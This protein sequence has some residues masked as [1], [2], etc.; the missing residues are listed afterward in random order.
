MNSTRPFWD[1]IDHESSFEELLNNSQPISQACLSTPICNSSM[2]ISTGSM[3]S[4]PLANVSSMPISNIINNSIDNN[5]INNNNNMFILQPHPQDENDQYHQQLS[6]AISQQQQTLNVFETM[7]VKFNDPSEIYYYACTPLGSNYISTKIR[8]PVYFSMFFEKLKHYFPLLMV[9]SMGHTVC[10]A[11]YSQTHCTLSDKVVLLNSLIQNFSK[12]ASNRQ[13]SFALICI[14][15]LVKT[16]T[17]I[18]VISKGFT[19]VIN[20]NNDQN[21]NDNDNNNDDEEENNNSNQSKNNNNNN[22]EFNN[23]ILS[24]SGYHVIKKFISFG[25]P[26]FDC[27]LDGISLNFTKYATHHYGV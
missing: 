16:N 22:N 17:E 7:A 3:S 14:M 1:F 6:A 13:G 24:Q 18:E 11:I 5:S 10:R 2:P 20:N 21:D 8:N 25:Y 23:I 26:H 4:V 27:I 19:S 12:I 15:S 9:N